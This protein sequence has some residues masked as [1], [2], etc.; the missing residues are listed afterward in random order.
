M[1]KVTETQ[2]DSI[3]TLLDKATKEQVESLKILL[4][5]LLKAE[6][7]NSNALRFSD[8]YEDFGLQ[9]T[10]Y[11]SP[12]IWIIPL[13]VMAIILVT[14]KR[15]KLFG[16]TQKLLILSITL[17][18]LFSLFA[19]IRDGTLH[20]LNMNYGFV[21]YKICIFLMASFRIQGI[22]H[23]SSLVLKSL[24]TAR[25]VVMF[26]FPMKLR[27]FRLKKWVAMFL[28]L[29]LVICT[30]SLFLMLMMQATPV[31]TVQEYKPEVSLKIIQAC[32][33]HVHSEYF[34]FHSLMTFS[35]I[36][37]FV[38][39]VYF[40]LI[41]ILFQC[42]C[43]VLLSVLMKKRIKAVMKLTGGGKQ[44]AEVNYVRLMKVSLLLGISFLIQEMPL[45]ISQV[46]GFTLELNYKLS[47]NNSLSYVLMSISY[48]V[49][50][51]IDMLI[52]ATQSKAFKT[53]LSK[54]LCQIKRKKKAGFEA[55]NRVKR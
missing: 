39:M 11:V 36:G 49:W 22:L 30:L 44:K 54:W 21:E 19:G 50:K 15:A 28:L 31:T 35:K 23:G 45:I 51:P 55:N 29:H 48:A 37:F 12:Y 2:I 25:I 42:V 6:R 3:K 53:T 20:F 27:T 9:F 4:D 32:E 7:A 33:M 1:E 18:T 46:N 5:N 14:F 17:D 43:I 24:M 40:L 13:T 16:I 26:A 52:Y 41:P 34:D 8:I 10:A 38:H 47:K